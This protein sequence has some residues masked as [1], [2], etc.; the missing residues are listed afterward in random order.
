M[1]PVYRAATAVPGCAARQPAAC[2]FRKSVE[3]R[4]G[5]RPCRQAND[6]QRLDPARYTR[7]LLHDRGEARLTDNLRIRR[8]PRARRLKLK[9]RSDASVEVVAPN[10]VSGADIRRFVGQH[11]EWVE[12]AVARAREAMIGRGGRSPFPESLPLRALGRDVR[13]IY[14]FGA[15]HNRSRGNADLLELSLRDRDPAQARKVLIAALRR[16]ARFGLEPRI[17]A[18]AERHGVQPTRVSWRNQSS[19]WGSCSSRGSLSMNIRLLFLPPELAEYVLVHELAH[20]THPNHSPAFWARV[21]QMLPGSVDARLRM[22]SADRYLP[23]WILGQTT[24]A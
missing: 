16:Q 6:L 14:R 8:H 20:L 3:P 11:S 21:E 17:A 2:G 15:E 1:Q 9:V 10:G 19:R 7:A 22:R 18:L 24:P 13:V 4:I 23:G 5:E 12:R